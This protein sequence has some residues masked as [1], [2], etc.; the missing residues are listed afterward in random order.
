MQCM[1]V[2]AMVG[3]RR[4]RAKR[5][6]MRAQR[7]ENGRSNDKRMAPRSLGNCARARHGVCLAV[8]FLLLLLVPGRPYYSHSHSQAKLATAHCQ[9]ESSQHQHATQSLWRLCS[10]PV[11][12]QP[13]PSHVYVRVAPYSRSFVTTSAQS[14]QARTIHILNVNPWSYNMRRYTYSSI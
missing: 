1:Y 5:Q 13:G 3:S 8:W 14:S 10:I 4:A 9:L 2:S 12:V 6:G 11:Q 7:I